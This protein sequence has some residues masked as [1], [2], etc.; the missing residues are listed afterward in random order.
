MSVFSSNFNVLQA[1][2][3]CSGV[4]PIFEYCHLNLFC[5]AGQLSSKR[6]N[7]SYHSLV[8]PVNINQ[9]CLTLTSSVKLCASIQS[10]VLRRCDSASSSG[11]PENSGWFL[12]YPIL[13]KY[14]RGRCYQT[15]GN[16]LCW[17]QLLWR[18][19]RYI[20]TNLSIVVYTTLNLRL[21]CKTLILVLNCRSLSLVCGTLYCIHKLTLS[22][23]I[24]WIRGVWSVHLFSNLLPNQNLSECL[25][26]L[27]FACF[28]SINIEHISFFSTGKIYFTDITKI[29]QILYY[30]RLFMVKNHSHVR[31]LLLLLISLLC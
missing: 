20:L 24:S 16:C 8:L 18:L 29:S 12:S 25:T 15:N 13:V 21:D 26:H 31:L 27:D 1:W 2:N 19:H 10:L 3:S 28:P 11:L 23:E 17:G 14:L 30:C 4:L 7:D 5:K 9:K 22:I 6:D